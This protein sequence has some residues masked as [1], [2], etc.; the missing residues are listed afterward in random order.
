MSEGLLPL[1]GERSTDRALCVSL[2]RILL[3]N[4]RAVGWTSTIKSWLAEYWRAYVTT[5]CK[6]NHALRIL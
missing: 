3:K 4:V 2:K 6:E 1:M 5:Y